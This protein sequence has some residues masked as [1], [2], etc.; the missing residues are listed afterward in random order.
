MRR[1]KYG[2]E[3]RRIERCHKRE[4]MAE[5]G[6]GKQREK[7]GEEGIGRRRGREKEREKGEGEGKKKIW[8]RLKKA[9]SSLWGMQ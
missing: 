6:V 8:I 3:A 7:G 1:V 4:Q 5:T 9:S 2:A